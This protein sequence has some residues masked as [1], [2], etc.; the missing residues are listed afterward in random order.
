MALWLAE[1]LTRWPAIG[2]AR[3]NRAQLYSQFLRERVFE[4]HRCRVIKLNVFCF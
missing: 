1:W 3:F 4:S 2:T